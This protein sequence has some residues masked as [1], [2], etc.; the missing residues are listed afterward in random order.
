MGTFVAVKV[1]GA[2]RHF[3]DFYVHFSRINEQVH[4]I[5]KP[6]AF[7]RQ[8]PA[9]LLLRDAAQACLRIADLCAVQ[10]FKEKAC[11]TIAEPAFGRHMLQAE[12]ILHGK[13]EKNKEP[14]LFRCMETA[15]FPNA[16]VLFINGSAC[17]FAPGKH[18]I[19]WSPA[20]LFQQP[21]STV[22]YKQLKNG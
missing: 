21:S 9:E 3:P 12:F 1:N 20:S 8:Q 19:E 16:N 14:A 15:V 2:D 7:Q 6:F 5:L 4:F 17:P 11:Q 22:C 10:G 13:E 18:P